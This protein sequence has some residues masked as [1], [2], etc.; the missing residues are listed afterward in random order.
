VLSEA[1]ITS[2]TTAVENVTSAWAKERKM[3]ERDSRRARREAERREKAAA[4]KLAADAKPE[5]AKNTVVGSGVLHR[6]IEAAA[7]ESM[8]SIKDLTVMSPQNA[9]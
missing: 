6:E 2:I 9:P 3:A 7:A 5:R 1:I 4:A 8:H